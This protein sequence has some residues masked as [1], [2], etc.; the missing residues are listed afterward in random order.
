MIVVCDGPI[1]AGS[2]EGRETL[3]TGHVARTFLQGERSL[4]ALQ[5]DDELAHL[6]N[7]F[8]SEAGD[9][10]LHVRIETEGITIATASEAHCIRL[11]GRTADVLL[12]YLSGQEVSIADRMDMTMRRTR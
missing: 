11:T 6:L 12:G 3:D 5:G 8:L 4:A 2:T 7:A 1:A 9:T 10:P